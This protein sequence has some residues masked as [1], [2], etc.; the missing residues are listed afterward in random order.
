MLVKVISTHAFVA[1]RF[2]LVKVRLCLCFIKITVVATIPDERLMD[3][4]NSIKLT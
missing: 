1:F 3:D 4:H 2:A